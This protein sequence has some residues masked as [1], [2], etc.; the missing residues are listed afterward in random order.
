M[1]SPLKSLLCKDVIVYIQSEF[2]YVK[3]YLNMS[4]SNKLFLCNPYQFN[5]RDNQDLN[6]HVPLLWHMAKLNY[7]QTIDIDKIGTVI[8]AT[9]NVKTFLKKKR[10]LEKRTF[11]KIQRQNPYNPMSDDSS[12]SDSSSSDSSPSDSLDHPTKKD[13]VLRTIFR[14]FEKLKVHT[15]VFRCMSMKNFPYESIQVKHII[16]NCSC[17]VALFPKF[18]KM[19]KNVEIVTLNDNFPQS[20]IKY[21]PK[22]IKQ[23]QNFSPMSISRVSKMKLLEILILEKSHESLFSKS[24]PPN[25]KYLK[26]PRS[27]N[28]VLPNILPDH[29][30]HIFLGDKYNQAFPENFQNSIISIRFGK[31]FKPQTNANLHTLK[32]LKHI[33]W[34]TK[35]P[36]L[37][38]PDS[39]ETLRIKGYFNSRI[40]V[41]L[42]KSLKILRFGKHYNKPLPKNL[43]S[44]LQYLVT[45]GDFN[46]PLPENMPR[47]MIGIIMSYAYNQELPQ[48]LPE[49]LKFI[50]LGTSYNQELPDNLPQTLKCIIL[51]RNYSYKLPETLPDSIEFIAMTLFLYQQPMPNKFPKNLK[52]IAC[53]IFKHRS[54]ITTM[55]HVQEVDGKHFLKKTTSDQNDDNFCVQIIP[56][57]SSSKK[58]DRVFLEQYFEKYAHVPQMTEF[59]QITN[60]FKYTL[61][62]NDELPF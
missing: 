9:C 18:M 23:L 13:M 39:V 54:I 22:T 60:R 53:E 15:M 20:L 44:S 6:T 25:L 12:S 52:Y 11:K 2:I 47:S 62:K 34:N 4:T 21:L 55:Y 41:E 50:E 31:S 46:L 10:A 1:Q 24:I 7:I 32:C 37:K 28:S 5:F 8:K 59:D 45:T 40:D 43:P 14:N 26:L 36:L 29:L 57:Q 3:D 33:V 35:H 16:L 48:K 58:K 42:P 19:L 49:K 56:T 51:P 38:L 61:F 30:K 27:Y 17:R